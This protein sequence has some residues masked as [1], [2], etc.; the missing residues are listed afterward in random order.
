[1][2]RHQRLQAL[3]DHMVGKVSKL[4]RLASSGFP[5]SAGWGVKDAM[6]FHKFICKHHIHV[7]LIKTNRM[8]YNMLY[9]I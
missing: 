8:I 3:G 5:K 2:T 6:E 4:L 9:K 1:M 7:L